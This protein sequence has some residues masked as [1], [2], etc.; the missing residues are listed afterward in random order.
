[1]PE[2]IG[3]IGLDTMVR[4]MAANFLNAGCHVYVFSRRPEQ[5]Q[6]LQKQGANFCPSPFEMWQTTPQLPLSSS[7]SSYPLNKKFF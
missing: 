1:M 6:T 7:L 2:Y 5:A 4:P 3:F